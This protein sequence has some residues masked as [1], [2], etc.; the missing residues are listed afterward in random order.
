MRTL[1]LWVL[2]LSTFSTRTTSEFGTTRNCVR[3]P[4]W[5]MNP[6]SSALPPPER[7]AASLADDLLDSMRKHLVSDIP[8]RCSC[9]E[10]LILCGRTNE[11]EVL[12]QHVEIHRG[13]AA[14]RLANHYIKQT[15]AR[16][17]SNAGVAAARQI[18]VGKTSTAT[19][20]KPKLR[21][22]PPQTGR[23]ELPL[24]RPGKEARL[25]GEGKLK[26]EVLAAMSLPSS[27]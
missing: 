25:S 3:R 2:D 4:I 12:R 19:A 6:Q 7:P 9:A 5:I 23:R 18:G 10:E 11:S 13:G 26:T 14:G 1:L 8:V 27:F 16:K 20:Q 24:T 22:L 15:S 21:A 17:S